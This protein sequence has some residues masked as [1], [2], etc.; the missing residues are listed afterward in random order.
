MRTEHKNI[1]LMIQSFM[2]SIKK[3][4]ET[5]DRNKKQP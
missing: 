4:Q 1:A 2:N 3:L 5:A